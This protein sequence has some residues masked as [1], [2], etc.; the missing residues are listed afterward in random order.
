MTDDD[1][2]CE[3]AASANPYDADAASGR[4][5]ANAGERND[6]RPDDGSDQ[7]RVANSTDER[8]SGVDC[9]IE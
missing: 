5:A 2:R 9:T 6:R 4:L 8:I 7:K 3:Y 1:G